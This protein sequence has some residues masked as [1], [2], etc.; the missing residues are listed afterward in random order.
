M[1]MIKDLHK[2]QTIQSLSVAIAFTPSDLFTDGGQV[3]AY[4]QH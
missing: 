2:H 1:M 3:S 4:P